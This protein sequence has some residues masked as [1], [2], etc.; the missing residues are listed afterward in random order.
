MQSPRRPELPPR[1][2]GPSSDGEP[3]RCPSERQVTPGPERVGRSVGFVSEMRS[4]SQRS[5]PHPQGGVGEQRDRGF[6]CDLSAAPPPLEVKWTTKC[7]PV[8]LWIR[9]ARPHR[10]ACAAPARDRN[11][12]IANTK[13]PRILDGALRSPMPASLAANRCCG[14]RVFPQG[15]RRKDRCAGPTRFRRIRALGQGSVPLGAWRSPVQIRLPDWSA[16][17]KR[18]AKPPRVP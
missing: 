17:L 3:P 12:A 4:Y 6:R 7:G 18:G 13:S 9:Y 15:R 16:R 2:K 1:P 14:I 10:A 5:L 11:R 8:T